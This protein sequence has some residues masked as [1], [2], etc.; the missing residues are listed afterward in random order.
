MKN[1][2]IILL[3]SVI[4]VCA[5]V[6]IYACNKDK[7][8][9]PVLPCDPN[10][11]Y[12]QRDVLPIVISNCAKSGCHDA[13]SAKE[14]LVLNSYSGVMKIVKAGSPSGSEL[15]KVITTTSSKDLMP[16]LPNT[17]LTQQQK[18]LISKWI[19]EGALNQTCLAD[20]GSC[21]S[22]TVSFAS[23]ITPIIN[24]NCVG[25]HG[26][27]NISG[28]IN[29]SNYAGIQSAAASGKLYNAVAQNGAA[30]SMPPSSKLSACDIKKI[31][32]WVD[33]GSK[34]N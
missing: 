14:G 12:F 5:I 27:T 2:K 1:S 18:D 34:N 4:V 22:T 31:K 15:I 30:I 7:T 3:N 19:S 28:N 24:T 29:L 10:K 23:N 16:P 17:P 8:P 11:T 13:A 32:T 25:C 6:V 33:D 9:T 26:G 21:A 20:T